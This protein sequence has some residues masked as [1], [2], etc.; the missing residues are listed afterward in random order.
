MNI[1]IDCRHIES[2]GV[3][4]YIKNCLPWLLD[5]NNYFSLIGDP[6]KLA[7][8]TWNRKNV[9]T[10]DCR[11]S[12]FSLRELFSFPSNCLKKINKSDLYY[13]PFF[14]IPGGIKVPVFTTIHDIIFPDMPELVSRTGLAE[15]MWF[16]R[17]AFAKSRKIFTVSGFSK[18]RIEYYSKGKVPV[19]VTYSAVRPEL[20]KYE[21]NGIAK[22]NNI[23][24]IGNIKKN[25]GLGCLLD[26]FQM[27]KAGG[28]SQ[29]LIIIGSRDHFRTA[30]NAILNKIDSLGPE[31]VVFTDFIPDWQLEKYLAE[32]SLLV[33]PSLYEGFGLPPLEAM[34]LGTKA[35]ISDIP[36]FREIYEGFPV[37]YFH[38]GDSQDL[39]NKIVEQLS[40]CSTNS[41]SLPEH[42][43]K[44]YTFENTA[45]VIINELEK[46]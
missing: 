34:V 9:E 35:L 39:K 26:A 16:Y 38:V 22:K 37:T 42:L 20:L 33:Q 32:A 14:N 24:F 17:R 46:K 45:S 27:A 21:K 31:S 2:S 40:N 15:R 36:V 8:F 13:S 12:P 43:L 28:I 4:V 25:K 29:K 6:G 5:S 19:T 18:S 41:I 10:L 1:A 3:G 44:K 30:D 7:P 23:V 11:I